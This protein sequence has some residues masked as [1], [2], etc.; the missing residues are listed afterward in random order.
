MTSPSAPIFRANDRKAIRAGVIRD[1]C[2]RAGIAGAVCFSCGNAAQALEAHA[3]PDFHVVSVYP[4]GPLAPGRWWT[5]ADIARAWPG[6]LDA[7]SGHLPAP[8][9]RD[10]AD[11][12]RARYG[13]LKPA[14]Y[15][16]PTGSGETLVALAMAYPHVAW[17][18]MYN[19][20]DPGTTRDAFAPLNALVDALARTFMESE[21]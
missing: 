21:R 11:A 9:M 1:Y 13:D 2:R 16:L 18:P 5:A 17:R 10:L 7:T 20:Q 6:H 12:Y 8:L 14:T 3:V 4:G 15:R 19:D